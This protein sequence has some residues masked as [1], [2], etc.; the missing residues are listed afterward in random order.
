[1]ASTYISEDQNKVIPAIK[2]LKK[3]FPDL[4]VA[5]DLCLC[6]FTDHGHCGNFC[7]F[8]DV[9]IC[10]SSCNNAVHIFLL[11]KFNLVFHRISRFQLSKNN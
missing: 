10:C 2:K 8:A 5:C 11:V 4:L 6:T 9:A 1:M 3:A 7:I